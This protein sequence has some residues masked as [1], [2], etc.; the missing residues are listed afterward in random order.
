[1]DGTGDLFSPFLQALPR[2]QAVRVV[3]Y[4]ADR[5]ANYPAL[6]RHVVDSLPAG[7]PIMIVAESFS[8]P[9]ALRLSANRSLKLRAV[10]VVC[11]FASRPLGF[12]GAIFARL[13]L[14]CLF[15]LRIP[16]LLLRRFLLG[17][18]A[19][20]ELVKGTVAAI[21]SV[22]PDVLAGRLREA[23]TSRYCAGPIL[24]ATRVVALFSQKDRLLGR[25]AR[26]SITE[27]VP[28]VGMQALDA[29]HFA[30]QAAPGQV[31]RKLADLDLLRLPP[32]IPD[33][34]RL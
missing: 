4:P 9:I 33:E 22:R 27:A 31:V 6:E 11:S 29:P 25:R 32:P 7:E 34:N 24:P 10:V 26:K 20:E 30:L 23:L 16:P 1:M 19:N 5:A 21:S 2:C 3:S 13:P 8:G 18:K 12:S 17:N 14:S 28:C 15:R